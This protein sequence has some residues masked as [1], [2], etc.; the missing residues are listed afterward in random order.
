MAVTAGVQTPQR[1]GITPSPVGLVV[2]AVLL[3][4]AVVIGAEAHEF[5]AEGDRHPTDQGPVVS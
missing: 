2:M 1:K 3:A 5:L 4:T